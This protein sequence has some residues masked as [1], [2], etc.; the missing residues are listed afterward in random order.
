MGEVVAVD[1]EDGEDKDVHLV[2]QA[3]HLRV[4]A[5]GGQSLGGGQIGAVTRRGLCRNA[6]AGVFTSPL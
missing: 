1:V 2:E 5:V 6:H 3:G 4:A